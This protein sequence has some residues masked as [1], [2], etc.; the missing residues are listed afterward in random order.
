MKMETL[1]FII[2]MIIVFIIIEIIKKGGGFGAQNMN[3]LLK[4]CRLH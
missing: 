3:I 2:N 4:Y 1:Y